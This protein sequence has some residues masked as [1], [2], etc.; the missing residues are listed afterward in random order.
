MLFRLIKRY[1]GD[2]C[3]LAGNS[4]PIGTIGTFRPF[5]VCLCIAGC[6]GHASV[7]CDSGS[8]G[9]EVVRC[10]EHQLSAGRR[11]KGSRLFSFERSARIEV[12]TP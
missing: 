10:V 4:G 1:R 11:S 9:P 3:V 2:C 6:V 5:M 8:R 12:P 7:H